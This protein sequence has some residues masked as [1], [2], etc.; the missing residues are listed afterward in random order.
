MKLGRVDD[1]LRQRDRVEALVL[2]RQAAGVELAGEED[3]PDDPGEALGLAVDHVHEHLALVGVEGNVLAPQR[4]DGAEHGRERRPQLVGRGGDEIAA[5]SLEEPLLRDVAEGVDGAVAEVHPGDRD[6]ALAAVAQD[7]R[8]SHGAARPRSLGPRVVLDLAPASDRAERRLAHD[9]GFVHRQDPGGR[10]VDRDD[11]AVFVEEDDAVVHV[12][13]RTRG[14]ASSLG[15]AVETRVVHGRGGPPRELRGEVEVELGVA[16]RGVVPDEGE[17]AERPAA[18]DERNGDGGAQPELADD[19]EQAL[20]TLR[21][22]DEELVGDLRD[23]LGRH[24]SDDVRHAHRLV[25]VGRVLLS[26]PLGPSDAI[27]VLVRDR[28]PLDRA[29]RP[30][31]VHG[32]PGRHLGDGEARELSEGRL[33]VERRAEE[34]ARVREERHPLP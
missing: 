32:A 24:R 12:G 29:V 3:L 7:E 22:L 17:R 27:G 33:V 34:L 9:R 4:L 13:E 16:R 15:L 21:S 19:L 31:H 26:Q 6:P 5:G 2:E 28:E 20:V 14:V 11:R 8:Q 18:R 23:E 1:A 30:E 10:R 25:G